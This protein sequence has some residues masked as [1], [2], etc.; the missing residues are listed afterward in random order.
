MCG[1]N[2]TIVI[3]WL[4]WI[5]GFA[6]SLSLIFKP[7]QLPT[8]A[9]WDRQ[10]H[11]S[12][13]IALHCLIVFFLLLFID[14]LFFDSFLLFLKDFFFSFIGYWRWVNLIEFDFLRNL[15]GFG[16][17]L[18]LSWKSQIQICVHFGLI[19]FVLLQF[20]FVF[21]KN[22]L[23]DYWSQCQISASERESWDNLE[24]FGMWIWYRFHCDHEIACSDSHT[25]FR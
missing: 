3:K 18:I 7:S 4:E 19:W 9:S 15:S 17:I 11:W 21:M 10:I 1:S 16:W 12:L 2:P 23:I 24:A 20:G 14:T 25:W 8:V 6:V 22:I 13:S 5:R